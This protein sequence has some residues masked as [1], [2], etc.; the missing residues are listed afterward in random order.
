MHNITISHKEGFA[1][2]PQTFD[3]LINLI[4]LSS[5]VVLTEESS[6]FLVAMAV[7]TLGSDHS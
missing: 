2:S 1:G 5:K 3:R 6:Q 7:K 4:K